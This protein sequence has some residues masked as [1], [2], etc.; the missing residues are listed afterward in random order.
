MV[1]SQVYL[2]TDPLVL[3]MA[4]ESRKI[5]PPPWTRSLVRGLNASI[6]WQLYFLCHTLLS[7]HRYGYSLSSPEAVLI[8]SF[9]SLGGFLFFPFDRRAK[10]YK[11]LKLFDNVEYR[12]CYAI[13]SICLWVMLTSFCSV[14][15]SLFSPFVYIKSPL[16][17]V[18]HYSVFVPPPPLL[19]LFLFV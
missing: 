13:C 10:W 12:I 15:Y 3:P 19:P 16:I 8:F 18:Y 4:L 1:V 14:N 6:V 2:P 7:K 11:G 9:G 17:L 5:L